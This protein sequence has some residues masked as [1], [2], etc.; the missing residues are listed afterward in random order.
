MRMEFHDWRPTTSGACVLN[1]TP[2]QRCAEGGT[3]QVEAQCSKLSWIFRLRFQAKFPGAVGVLLLPR[4][5]ARVRFN[6]SWALQ[7]DDVVVGWL[8]SSSV[9]LSSA[10]Y[11]SP[12]E[13]G[14]MNPRFQHS[15]CLLLSSPRS[16]TE[17]VFASMVPFSRR[18][19][20]RSSERMSSEKEC[21]V[22]ARSRCFLVMQDRS[23]RTVAFVCD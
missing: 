23:Q 6:A 10:L 1:G 2:S 20:Y 9:S 15:C 17:V 21:F 16:A 22:V 19:A 18:P 4:K 13:Q 14:H 3:F 8:T 7:L 11:L 5:V 12:D